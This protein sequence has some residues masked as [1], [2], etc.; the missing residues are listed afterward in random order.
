MCCLLNSEFKVERF[1]LDLREVL[2]E[3]I[4]DRPAIIIICFLLISPMVDEDLIS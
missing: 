3:W 4:E 2:V 1:V